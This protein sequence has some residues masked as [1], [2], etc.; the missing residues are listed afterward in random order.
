MALPRPP[1]VGS[2]RSPGAKRLTRSHGCAGVCRRGHASRTRAPEPGHP[3]L[4]PCRAGCRDHTP[5]AR[6][7]AGR[8]RRSAGC[9][10]CRDGAC[11]SS[12]TG[13]ARQSRRS[14][15]RLVMFAFHSRSRARFCRRARRPAIHVTTLHRRHRRAPPVWR[16]T[17][18]FEGA[19]RLTSE[20]GRSCS[21]SRCGGT[22][23]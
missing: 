2:A 22:G 3:A 10:H 18:R 8:A 23:T 6:G 17:G 19:P 7:T 14:A 20:C 9:F 1:P 21:V 12:A 11:A 5:G 16:S 15:T 13:S 4:E